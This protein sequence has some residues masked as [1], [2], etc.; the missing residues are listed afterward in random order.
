MVYSFMKLFIVEIAG[1]LVYNKL[2]MFRAGLHPVVL[3]CY[4]VNS[5]KKIHSPMSYS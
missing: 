3:V 4:Q 1:G 5:K 2:L